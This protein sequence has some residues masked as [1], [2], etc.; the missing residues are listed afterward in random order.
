MP[1]ISLPTFWH[2][3]PLVHGWKQKALEIE[4]ALKCKIIVSDFLKVNASP[5][6]KEKGYDLADFLVVKDKKFGWALSD[7]SYPIFWDH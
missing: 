1:P 7:Y 5:I 2:F 6:E 4:K 3:Q